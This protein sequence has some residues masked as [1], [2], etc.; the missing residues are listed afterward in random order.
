MKIEIVAT[1]FFAPRPDDFSPQHRSPRRKR[2]S[3]LRFYAAGLYMLVVMSGMHRLLA[4]VH[5]S[6]SQKLREVFSL[7]ELFVWKTAEN[8]FRRCFPRRKKSGMQKTTFLNYRLLL[9]ATYRIIAYA[10]SRPEWNSVSCCGT[11]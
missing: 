8:R 5:I 7:S 4:R 10:G 6:A 11:N 3:G 1:T 2:A 9:A